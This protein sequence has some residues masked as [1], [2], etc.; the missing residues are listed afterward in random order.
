MKFTVIAK[1]AKNISRSR[2]LNTIITRGMLQHV[3]TN[4]INKLKRA[5]NNKAVS[6]PYIRIILRLDVFWT[7]QQTSEIGKL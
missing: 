6:P 2:C 3:L 1:K 7:K 5:S 4:Q